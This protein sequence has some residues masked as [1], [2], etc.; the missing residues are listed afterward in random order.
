MD[1]GNIQPCGVYEDIIQN[2][3]LFCYKELTEIE[4]GVYLDRSVYEY[5]YYGS[6][7]NGDQTR[8][9]KEA[10]VVS[11]TFQGAYVIFCK[12]SLYNANSETYDGRHN[13]MTD[14]KFALYMQN[15][16]DSIKKKRE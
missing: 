4:S 14:E 15:S 13:K 16:V 12:A 8:L 5:G 3:D 1:T 10:R 9:P 7:E 2:N 6:N 11:R